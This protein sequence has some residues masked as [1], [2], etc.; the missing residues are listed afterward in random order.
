MANGYI[1]PSD[2][3]AE[4]R[5]MIQRANRRVLANL[6]YL[7]ENDIRDNHVKTLLAGDFTK[8]KTWATQKSPFSSKTRFE[9]EKAYQEFMRYVSRWGEDTGGRGGHKADPKA[10]AERHRSDIYKTINGLVRNKSISLEEWGGDLPPEL[11]GRL[12][13]LSLEQLTHFY[14]YLDPETGGTEVFDSD[15]VDYEDVDDFMDYI[16]GILG[17]VEKFYPA[18]EKK[19]TKKGKKRKSRRK[20]KGRK[21]S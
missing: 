19:V 4:Y 3:Q 1:V 5:R 18:P 7:K 6:K 15:Q 10:I 13:G 14:R 9:S 11:K 20:T 21:K 8:K 17:A 2:A 16:G 12:E